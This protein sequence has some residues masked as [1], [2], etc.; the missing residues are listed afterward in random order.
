MVPLRTG[1][2]DY[3]PDISPVDA[4]SLKGNSSFRTYETNTPLTYY[5]LALD[6]QNPKL[7]DV[8]VRQAI[9]YAINIPEII[10]ANQQP[11]SSRLNSIIT[12][13]CGAGYWAGA[14]Q[15]N[16]DVAKAKALLASAGVKNLTLE[17][18]AP[19][20]STLGGAPDNA[21][22]VIKQNLGQVGITVNI[23]ETPPNTYVSKAGFGQ[24][25]W[26]VYN[27]APDPYTQLQWWT[28]KQ[29][30][31]WNY[32]SWC[33]KQYGDLEN[34]LARTSDLATRDAIAIKMQQMIDEAVSY[35]WISIGTGASASSARIRA[36][37]GLGG[38]AML[39]YFRAT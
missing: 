36:V 4:A 26:N 29:V 27:G 5:F 22:Q 31:V 7:K 10:Q 21:M 18:A 39:N 28:C 3:A 9:R 14:P 25:V 20:A 2:V 17:I 1:A 13:A 24:L 11:L 38:F 23:I 15:Y 19:E 32:A 33:N 8:R 34:A 12:R 30:G 6:V 35:I 37:F 16:R